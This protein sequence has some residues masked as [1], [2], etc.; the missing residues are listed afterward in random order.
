MLH[1]LSWVKLVNIGLD[2][3]VLLILAT[4]PALWE[5]VPIYE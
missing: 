4:T 3:D 2:D 1:L 5:H